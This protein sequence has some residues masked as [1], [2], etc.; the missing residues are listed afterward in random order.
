MQPILP[1]TET[2]KGYLFGTAI[3]NPFSLYG[4]PGP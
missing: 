1:T 4:Q 2:K 3:L